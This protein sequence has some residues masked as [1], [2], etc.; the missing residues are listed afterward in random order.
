MKKVSIIILII[1]LALLQSCVSA[2][3][4]QYG[5][6]KSGCASTKGKVGYH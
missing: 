1:A 2:E 6:D 4:R 3:F 5:S